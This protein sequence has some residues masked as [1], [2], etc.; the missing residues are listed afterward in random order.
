VIVSLPWLNPREQLRA[1]R[2][3]RSRF[4]DC[5]CAHGT[6]AFLL[7]LALCAW[8]R[9]WTGSPWWLAIPYALLAALLAAVPAKL[10]ALLW[11]RWRLRLLLSRLARAEPR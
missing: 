2:V 11:S 5:G 3:L 8:T 6:V 10:A 1:A 4:N 7:V 9:P